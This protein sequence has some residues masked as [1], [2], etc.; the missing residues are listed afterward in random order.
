MKATTTLA[1]PLG[2]GAMLFACAG[3]APPPS[4]QWT[5]AETAIGRAQAGGAPGVP[6]AKLHL[7]LALEDLQRAKQA[8]GSD[9][10]RA[11]TLLQ[12]ADTEAHLALSLAK[13]ARADDQARTAEEDSEEGQRSAVTIAARH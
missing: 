10:R 3:S 8:T 4:D 7:Q 2:M 13:K 12:V 9:N 6:E 5:A 1:V 11:R